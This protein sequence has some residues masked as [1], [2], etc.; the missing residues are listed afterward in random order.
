MKNFILLEE[1]LK[2]KAEEPLNFHNESTLNFSN[3][4]RKAM[5]DVLVYLEI[6]KNENKE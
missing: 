5:M 4:Y 3:I 1:W 2:R 6:L